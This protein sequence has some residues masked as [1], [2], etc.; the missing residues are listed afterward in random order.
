VI[1]YCRAYPAAAVG[2]HPVVA[3]ALADRVPAPE[4]VYLWTDLRL[5]ATP[6]R[7]DDNLAPAADDPQWTQFCVE[8]LGFAGLPDDLAALGAG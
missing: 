7:D 2:V 4:V 8:D 3:A 5:T 6:F 1:V